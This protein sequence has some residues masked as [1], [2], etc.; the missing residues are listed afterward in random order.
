MV[1]V[2][3]SI[4]KGIIKS[5]RTWK[6]EQTTRTSTQ[7]RHG[8][9]GHLATSYEDKKKQRQLKDEVK[10]L[11]KEM[12]DDIKAKKA[13]EKLRREEQEKRRMANEF[14]TATFQ[15]IKPQ[16]LKG[17]SKKQLRSIKKTAMNQ[18]GQVELVPLYETNSKGKSK[19]VKAPKGAK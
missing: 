12:I 18:N 7:K 4:P 1:I 19:R 13:A 16:K 3:E 14:K 8:V 2:A 11:E 15:E 6:S 9:S 17:M 10:Q 5:G